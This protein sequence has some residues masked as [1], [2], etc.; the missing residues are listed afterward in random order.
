MDVYINGKWYTIKDDPDLDRDRSGECSAL[1]C[2]IRIGPDQTEQQRRDTVWHEVKH[3]IFF[4]TGL[5]TEIE[6]SE[7]KVTEEMI[8]RRTASM[9]L[10]VLR[11]NPD[12]VAYLTEDDDA[13]SNESR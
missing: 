9:E 7:P 10:A 12:L 2:V 4:E 1:H 11:E 3:A 13:G 5:N 8:V 6:E